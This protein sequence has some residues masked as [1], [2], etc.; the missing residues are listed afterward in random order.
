MRLALISDI[1]G[2]LPALKTVLEDIETKAIDQVICLGDLVDFA[3]WP[4]EAI[5][6]IRSL[7]IMT[8]MGNHDERI[9]FDQAII[10]LAKH[11][12]AET[13]DRNKAI[14]HSKGMVTTDNKRYLASLPRNI[15]MQFEGITLFC[16]HASP[17]SIDEYLY[18]QEDDLLAQRLLD[19]HADVLIIGHTHFSFI[20]DIAGKKVINT[21]SVGRSKEPDQKACYVIIDIQSGAK[22]AAEIIKLPYP[23]QETINAIYSSEIP[24]VYAGLL[25]ENI[26]EQLNN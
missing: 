3:P 14:N 9:A 18:E 1:H 22:I 16:T 20:K 17:E 7:K 6:L 11:S 8:V 13:M 25:T 26:S 15:V 19:S 24:D 23:V 10:P 2:N 5:N 21:G 4:N 12:V